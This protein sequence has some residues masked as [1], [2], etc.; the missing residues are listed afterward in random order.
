MLKG[1]DKTTETAT[2][3]RVCLRFRVDAENVLQA[4]NYRP[5][6]LKGVWALFEARF[7]K[8]KLEWS[9]LTL[10]RK[11]RKSSATDR[12]DPLSSTAH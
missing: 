8:R 11:R 4:E 10:A 1:R 7:D 12:K 9:G 5:L 3:F 2:L 6:T